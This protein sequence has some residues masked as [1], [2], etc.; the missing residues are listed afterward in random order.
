MLDLDLGKIVAI[1]EGGGGGVVGGELG[2]VG[3]LK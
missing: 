2:F 1:L 3:V